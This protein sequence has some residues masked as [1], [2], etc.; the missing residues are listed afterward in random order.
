MKLL[1]VILFCIWIYPQE[2][3]KKSIELLNKGKYNEA[4]EILKKIYNENPKSVEVNISLAISYIQLKKYEK[5]EKH[6]LNVLKADKK[7]VIAHYLL[8]L[9]YEKKKNYDKAIEEWKLVQKF[10]KDKKV[11]SLAE[12]HIQQIKLRK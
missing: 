4:I 3:M 2:L 8:A 7:S 1:L 5:A 12:K 11:K 10:T 9:I 6:L